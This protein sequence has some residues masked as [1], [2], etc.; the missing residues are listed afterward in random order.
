MKAKKDMA[1]S[2]QFSEINAQGTIETGWGEWIRIETSVCPSR[3]TEKAYLAEITVYRCDDIGRSDIF[4]EETEHWVPKSM[5]G[6]VWWICK[7]I[8]EHE[9]KISNKRYHDDD[10]SEY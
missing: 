9:L 8:F 5:S 10:Y 7:N 3:E 4:F 6:N 1:S 2:S